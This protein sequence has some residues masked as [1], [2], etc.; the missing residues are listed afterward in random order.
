MKGH[1]FRI[2]KTAYHIMLIYQELKCC[3]AYL[4]KDHVDHLILTVLLLV[5]FIR[6]Y[7]DRFSFKRILEFVV[8]FPARWD[9]HRLL[10]FV[11]CSSGRHTSKG[12]H[13]PSLWWILGNARILEPVGVL[14]FSLRLSTIVRHFIFF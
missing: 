8:L 2:W 5:L 1:Q 13:F 10:T 7:C 3:T 11:S 12:Q 14:F 6:N 4:H 9:C